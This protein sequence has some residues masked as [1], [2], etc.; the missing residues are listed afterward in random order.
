MLVALLSVCVN[1]LDAL[2]KPGIQESRRASRFQ[3]LKEQ[4]EIFKRELDD[5]LV[6]TPIADPVVA[7]P[8]E[9]NEPASNLAKRCEECDDSSPEKRCPTGCGGSKK[10]TPQKAE[11]I[12]VN[13][14][15]EMMKRFLKALPEDDKRLVE[16]SKSKRQFIERLIRRSHYGPNANDVAAEKSRAEERVNA[17]SNIGVRSMPAEDSGVVLAFK[18][19]LSPSDQQLL[20]KY[21]SKT[22]FIEGVLKKA[23]VHD[24]RDVD[25]PKR[26]AEKKRQFDD[27]I[28][29]KY[30][31]GLDDEQK[32]LIL[33]NPSIVEHLKEAILKG[34]REDQEEKREL[35]PDQVQDVLNKLASKEDAELVKQHLSKIEKVA[36]AE[37]RPIGNP[38]EEMEQVVSRLVTDIKIAK[39]RGYDL[40]KLL[41]A[42]KK[43]ADE[44]ARISKNK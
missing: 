43:R 14:Q 44:K 8:H 19:S 38:D 2:P 10:P 17:I 7:G 25:A 15:S 33:K 22:R 24:K 21:K 36:E 37:K 5:L 20:Q 35:S 39:K 26:N 16:G 4:F 3:H 29:A 40:E 41:S 13:P 34:T 1:Q 31:E 6:E 12:P 23:N 28:V 11:V 27:P 30:L 9:V 18:R 42:M 32:A